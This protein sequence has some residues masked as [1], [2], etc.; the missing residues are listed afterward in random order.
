MYC[1]VERVAVSQA[2][3]Y[4]MELVGYA[5]VKEIT[6]FVKKVSASV[7]IATVRN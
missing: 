6:F 1:F 7:N 4:G 5:G 2:A 3:S